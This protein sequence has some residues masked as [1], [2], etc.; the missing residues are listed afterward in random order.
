MLSIQTVTEIRSVL[1]I[2]TIDKKIRRQG[3]FP[4]SF[5]CIIDRMLTFVLLY[6][7]CGIMARQ[8]VTLMKMI[9]WERI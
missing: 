5:Q 9:S 7:N 1:V 4:V 8:I 6:S 2:K 3:I